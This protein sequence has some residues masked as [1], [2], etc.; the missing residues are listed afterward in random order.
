MGASRT[1][2]YSG[3]TV[4][5]PPKHLMA[6]SNASE[7]AIS[8]EMAKMHLEETDSSEE[9]SPRSVSPVLVPPAAPTDRYVFAFDIDG[10]LI[11]GGNVIPAAVK[12]MK[13]L[14]GENPHGVKV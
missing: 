14:N 13:V 2:L 10:V 6:L 5:V 4:L 3:P 7:T 9:A 1:D 8:F 12:A 11:R